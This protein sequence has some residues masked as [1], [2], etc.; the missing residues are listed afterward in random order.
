MSYSV[1]VGKPILGVAPD[2]AATKPHHVKA[3]DG[4]TTHFQNTCLSAAKKK[5]QWGMVWEMVK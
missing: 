3:K 1:S 4:T 5:S 2:D